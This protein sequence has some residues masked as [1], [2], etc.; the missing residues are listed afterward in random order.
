MN[1]TLHRRPEYNPSGT[2]ISY[3]AKEKNLRPF[4]H[5]L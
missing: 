4:E 2:G 5:Q 3:Y 1:A